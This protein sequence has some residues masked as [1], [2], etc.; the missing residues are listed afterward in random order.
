MSRW[1]AM[2]V[3]GV[4][5][6]AAAL[7]FAHVAF[8]LGAVGAYLLVSAILEQVFEPGEQGQGE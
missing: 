2:E 5:L 4:A 3:A 7:A 8:A 1:K 6:I